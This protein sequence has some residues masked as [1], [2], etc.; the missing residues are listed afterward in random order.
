M[1]HVRPSVGNVL[2]IGLIAVGAGI[3]AITL[4]N[5]FSQKDVPIISPTARGAVD[6]LHG[7]AV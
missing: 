2:F 3:T 5:H 6:L 4:V 7:K 1:I